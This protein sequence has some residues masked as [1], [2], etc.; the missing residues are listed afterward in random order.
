MFFDQ[1]NDIIF[2]EDTPLSVILEG[3]NKTARFTENKGFCIIVNAEGQATGVISDGDIRHH[4]AKDNDLSVV[5]GQ[6]AIRDFVFAWEDDDETVILRLF[7]DKI[8][9]VPVISRTR[10]PVDLICYSKFNQRF[11]LN[12][13]IIRARVPAR[14]SYSGGGLD[15]TEIFNKTVTNVLSSTINR[16]CT[17]SLLVRN[18]DAIHIVSKNLDATYSASNVDAIEYGDDL[19]LVK[20]AIKLI[21][22]Q[23]G[24]DIE[25]YSDIEHG[26]GLGG[27]SA[28]VASVIGAI[29]MMDL[30][31]QMNPY[32]MANLAYQIERIELKNKGGWQDQFST[33]FGGFNMIEFMPDTI[34]VNPL[35]IQRETMLELEYNLLLFRVG[36]NR[37]SSS[38]HEKNGNLKSSKSDF[39]R[40]T[41]QMNENTIGMKNALLRGRVKQF[42]DMLHNAW[43]LKNQINA[44]VSNTLIDECY[45]KARQIGALGGKLLGAGR[46]G[47]LLIHASPL[48]HLEIIQTLSELGARHEQFSF[49]EQG[50][51][52]WKVQK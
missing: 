12:R 17:T 38:V 52:A 42:G 7:E 33:V 40:F 50:L 6:L 44:H 15:M 31:L 1:L 30:D 23:V 45:D 47:Y 29:N 5:A 20:A 16:F 25:I 37:S 48:Y 21:K 26:T 11:K 24:M 22:P 41:R 3:M 9:T 10:K 34:T 18:D 19:D 39:D 28:V 2:T 49:T 36:E 43:K 51:E 46:S 35:R 8:L 32:E 13:N 14:M 4:L 27:S